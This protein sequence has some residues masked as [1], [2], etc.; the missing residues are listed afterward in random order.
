[1]RST[2]QKEDAREDLVKTLA[3][4]RDRD[5]RPSAAHSCNIWGSVSF[6]NT[7]NRAECRGFRESAWAACYEVMSCKLAMHVQTMHQEITGAI[8]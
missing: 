4:H 1:M 8:P 3:L 6:I 2:M 7:R 5:P